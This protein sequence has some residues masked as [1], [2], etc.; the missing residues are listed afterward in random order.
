[1]IIYSKDS[2]LGGLDPIALETLIRFLRAPPLTYGVGLDLS[3]SNYFL[4][5][6]LSTR[7]GACPEENAS[8][9]LVLGLR[10]RFG[11]ESLPGDSPAWRL[12][13]RVVDIW[14]LIIIYSQI[15]KKHCC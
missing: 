4:F 7:N 1:M 13:R 5:L 11:T 15:K 8:R 3:R 6:L 9:V 14:N 10:A 2:T 12:D